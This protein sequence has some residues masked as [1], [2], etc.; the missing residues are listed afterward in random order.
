MCSHAEVSGAVC[1][2]TISQLSDPSSPQQSTHIMTNHL[3]PTV[4]TATP[5][6]IGPRGLSQCV[7][8]CVW[9]RHSLSQALFLLSSNYQSR[10]LCDQSKEPLPLSHALFSVHFSHSPSSHSPAFTLSLT[11]YL[12]CFLT[13]PLR[14]SL[15]FTLL[16]VVTTPCG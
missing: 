11:L 6:H 2:L 12:L 15:S 10:D 8:V 3:L 9:Y 16:V 7:C 13:L 5:P 1:V 4:G 14:F